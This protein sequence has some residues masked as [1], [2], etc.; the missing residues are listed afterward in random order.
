MKAD[1]DTLYREGDIAGRAGSLVG[2]LW[3]QAELG[4]ESEAILKSVLDYLHDRT[5]IAFEF[6]LI[7]I[8]PNIRKDYPRAFRA[9]RKDRFRVVWLEFDLVYVARRGRNHGRYLVRFFIKDDGS[10]WVSCRTSTNGSCKGC[11]F[12]DGCCGHI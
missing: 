9:A 8:T 12:G 4:S 1:W 2:P 3:V 11:E 5:M 6:S 7:P 10:V